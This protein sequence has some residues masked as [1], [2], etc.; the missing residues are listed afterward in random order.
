ML[1]A[2]LVFIDIYLCQYIFRCISVAVDEFQILKDF[3]ILS[4]NHSVLNHFNNKTFEVKLCNRRINSKVLF[5]GL[6]V[7]IISPEK[8]DNE[9]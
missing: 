5:Q 3:F 2:L 8:Q 7:H 4:I 6:F 9:L 1:Y